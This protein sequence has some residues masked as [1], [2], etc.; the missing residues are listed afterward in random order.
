[1]NVQRICFLGTRT[2]DF[3]ATSALF[4][5]VLGLRNVHSEAGW[6]IFQL[7]SRGAATSLRSLVPSM[8][9]RAS[10]RLG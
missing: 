5:D 1:M 7:P 3:D 10:S 4:R 6:S 9:T 8:R 2:P